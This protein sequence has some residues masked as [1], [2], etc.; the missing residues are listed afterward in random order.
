MLFRSGLEPEFIIMLTDGF[1]DSWP[2]F[3]CPTLWVVTTKGIV[4]R[5]GMTIH[6]NDD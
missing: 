2:E 6:L 1:V 5:T 3:D 4:A